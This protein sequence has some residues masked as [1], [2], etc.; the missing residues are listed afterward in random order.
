MEKEIIL[1][2]E[3]ECFQNGRVSVYVAEPFDLN[4]LLALINSQE[5]TVGMGGISV[6]HGQHLGLKHLAGLAAGIGQSGG[7]IGGLPSEIMPATCLY[8]G[9][10]LEGSML[11]AST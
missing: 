2:W 9:V 10:I 4:D 7:I 5:F 6:L 3:V 11:P 8:L 1:S